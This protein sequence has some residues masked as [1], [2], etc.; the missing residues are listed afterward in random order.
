ALRLRLLSSCAPKKATAKP[1]LFATAFPA[2][3]SRNTP[4]SRNARSS[5][6]SLSASASLLQTWKPPG[7]SAGFLRRST[8]SSKTGTKPASGVSQ[9]WGGRIGGQS[10]GCCR[11]PSSCFDFATRR[12]NGYARDRCDNAPYHDVP[13]K[14]QLARTCTIDLYQQPVRLDLS[15]FCPFD[16]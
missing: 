2:R 3:F 1:A 5:S 8:P 11:Q 9:P 10:S 7:T 12:R 14:P 16:Q 13:E 6:Q 4:I 15:F